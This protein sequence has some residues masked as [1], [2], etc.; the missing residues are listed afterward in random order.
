MEGGHPYRSSVASFRPA[1]L[2]DVAAAPHCRVHA[3]FRPSY[4]DG[5]RLSLRG[6]SSSA[7][8]A[9]LGPHAWRPHVGPDVLPS[10][11]ISAPVRL[12]TSSARKA[13]GCS[14]PR[15]AASAAV[16]AR[17][18][19]A[20]AL[21]PRLASSPARVSRWGR[22]DRWT[23]ERRNGRAAGRGRVSERQGALNDIA[24]TRRS[25]G[26]PSR[27]SHLSR[28]RAANPVVTKLQAAWLAACLGL[29]RSAFVDARSAVPDGAPPKLL[30]D[31]DP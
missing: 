9:L 1:F 5:R 10:L 7:V 13:G 31:V 18:R 29:R 20:A 25:H 2:F 27:P 11:A 30:R 19:A 22:K 14:R 6:S 3:F 4:S 8:L 23:V 12:S 21:C 15:T 16:R 24:E 28:G 17:A 26:S